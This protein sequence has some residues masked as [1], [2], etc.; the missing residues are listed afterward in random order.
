M[1][2]KSGE[3]AGPSKG[4]TI[5]TWIFWFSRETGIRKTKAFIA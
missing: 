4:L 1:A 2:E 5:E 3:E